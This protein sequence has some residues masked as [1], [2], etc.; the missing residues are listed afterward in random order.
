[1]GGGETERY[2]SQV[3]EVDG[4]MSDCLSVSHTTVHTDTNI[5]IQTRGLDASVWFI[6]AKAAALAAAACACAPRA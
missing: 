2:S 1:M 6:K 4:H 5:T 3:V